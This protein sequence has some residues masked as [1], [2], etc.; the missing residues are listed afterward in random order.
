MGLAA[1]KDDQLWQSCPFLSPSS[2][3][4]PTLASCPFLSLCSES[5]RAFVGRLATYMCLPQI[6]PPIAGTT[7]SALLSDSR[8]LKLR[9]YNYTEQ[10]GRLVYLLHYSPLLDCACTQKNRHITTRSR[11]PRPNNH[12]LS[13]SPR[14]TSPSQ[15]TM[16]SRI[17]DHPHTIRLSTLHPCTRS[18]R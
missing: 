1:P 14:S 7:P 9:S 10:D 16:S 17:D 8:H 2:E 11:T 15:I 6:H 5:G 4:G 3:S 18:F 12:K 13:S